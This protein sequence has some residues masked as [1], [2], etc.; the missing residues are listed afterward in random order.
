MGLSLRGDATTKVASRQRVHLRP[1]ARKARAR[2]ED[3]EELES[4]E[5]CNLEVDQRDAKFYYDALHNQEGVIVTPAGMARE[6]S[7]TAGVTASASEQWLAVG[8]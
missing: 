8:A 5:D 2:A 7:S 6:R 4:I 1:Q 3:S